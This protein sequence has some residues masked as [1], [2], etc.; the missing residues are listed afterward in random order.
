MTVADSVGLVVTEGAEEREAVREIVAE[1]D[2]P[3]GVEVCDGL[4]V[5]E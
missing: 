3:E 1:K 5:G 4:L 2:T